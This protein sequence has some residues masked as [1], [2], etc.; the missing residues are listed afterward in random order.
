[1]IGISIQQAVGQLLSHAAG[2]IPDPPPAAP[3][4]SGAIG[5]LFSWLKWGALTCCAGAAVTGGCMIALGNTS[6]R[7]EMAERGKVTLFSSVIGAVVVALA[8]TLVTASYG[9]GS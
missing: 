8:V 3:V 7:A 9:L 4:G 6:R 5:T 1:M 2:V